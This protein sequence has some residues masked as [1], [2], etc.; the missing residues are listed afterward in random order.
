MK[1]ACGFRCVLSERGTVWVARDEGEVIGIAV[2]HDSDEER[3]VGDLFVEPSYRGQGIGARLLRAAFAQCG[4]GCAGRCRS[5]LDDAASLAL[6]LRFGM[7][8]RD[9]V[10]R[11]AGAIPREEE[12]A[13]MA[14]GE[15]RFRVDAVDPVTH[16]FALERARSSNPRDACG[17]RITRTSLKTA[18]AKSS[19]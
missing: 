4:R 6:A 18:P 1:P 8:T 11:F 2:A 16:A 12:L 13:K 9:S 5:I 15:Y 14:A 3:Y 10:V 19:F 7:A 17:R